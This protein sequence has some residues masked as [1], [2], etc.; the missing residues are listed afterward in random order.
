[1][2]VKSNQVKIYSRLISFTRDVRSS[3]Q[4]NISIIAVDGPVSPKFPVRFVRQFWYIEV[5]QMSLGVITDG[6][7]GEMY[8][9]LV[10]YLRLYLDTNCK[11]HNIDPALSYSDS[12]RKLKMCFNGRR[13]VTIWTFGVPASL[14][15]QVSKALKEKYKKLRS[16]AGEDETIRAACHLLSISRE[17][18]IRSSVGL[19]ANK[20]W[21]IDFCKRFDK[22]F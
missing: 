9:K 7:R 19:L 12:E 18:L 22:R 20:K 1:M 5:S 14:E 11:K 21:F 6:D 13:T 8:D 16:L 10:E 2:S 15:I 17:D 3:T 4:A